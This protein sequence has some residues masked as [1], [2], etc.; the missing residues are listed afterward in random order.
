MKKRL[1]APY[2]ILSLVGVVV[3]VSLVAGYLYKKQFPSSAS[4]PVSAVKHLV[5]PFDFSNQL[6]MMD[7]GEVKFSNGSFKTPDGTHS[8]TI[9]QSAVNS[10]GN[11]AAAILT[12]QPGGSGTFY[13]IVGASTIEDVTYYSL[14]LLIGDRIKVQSVTMDNPAEHDDG[15]IIVT[16]LDRQPKDPMSTE[17]TVSKTAKFAFEKTGNLISVLH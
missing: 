16:Y 12:D 3:L 10:A 5:S 14:P 6:I 11:R 1:P 9:S 2:L 7:Y 13:Y 8:A 17:P 4:H 15:V